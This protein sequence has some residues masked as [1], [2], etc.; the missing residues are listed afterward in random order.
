MTESDA[1]RLLGLIRAGRAIH[2][3]SFPVQGVR[4]HPR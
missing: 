2:G 4:F 1:D 3:S